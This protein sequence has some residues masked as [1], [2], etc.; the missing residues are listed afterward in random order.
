[1]MFSMMGRELEFPAEV[2]VAGI[3]EEEGDC[4]TDVEN[5]VH[6]I[7]GMWFIH[8]T[9]CDSPTN[10]ANQNGPTLYQKSVKIGP[11]NRS[12]KQ[13]QADSERSAFSC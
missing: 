1:M 9:T 11:L 3:G 8:A 4:D 13:R 12:H 2:R 5:V 10:P 7:V 6:G